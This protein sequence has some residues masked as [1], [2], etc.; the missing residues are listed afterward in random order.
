MNSVQE[1]AMTTPLTTPEAV[2]E[3]AP[4]R[5]RWAALFVILAAEVMALL[6]AMVTNIAAPSMRADLGG[7]AG[8]IQW[9]AAA[10]TLAM[11]GGLLTGGR[12]GD[13]FGKKRMFVV[14]A[15]GFTVGSLL[16]AIA[17]SPEMLIGARVIQGLFGAVMMPQGLG[18]IKEIF[19]PK[20]MQ[21]AFALF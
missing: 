18:I 15:I 7:G 14:G 3:A 16:C 8:T 13:I 2:E 12:L 17:M 21:T 5:W 11:T 6:D 20:E 4:Y 10:Y 19:P 9:L 1:I